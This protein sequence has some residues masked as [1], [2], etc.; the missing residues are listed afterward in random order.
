M[1]SLPPSFNAI[2]ARLSQTHPFSCLSLPQL[3]YAVKSACVESAVAGQALINEGSGGLDYLV[4]LDGELEVRRRFLNEQGMLECEVG[5]L[6]PG[7]GAGELALLRGIS[8]QA[9]VSAI[10]ASRYLRINGECMEELLAWSQCLTK[11]LN[12]VAEARERMNLV[13]QAGPF[14][15]LPLENVQRAFAALRPMVVKDG[16]VIIRQGDSGDLY[17]IIERGVAE[18]SRV[19]TA[20]GITEA[21]AVIGP[22]DGFGEEALLLGGFRNATVK[23]QTNGCLWTLRKQ[24]FDVLV[25]PTVVE[26]FSAI[27]AQELALSN[28]VRWI[29]CRYEVELEEGFLPGS[30]HLPLDALRHSTGILDKHHTYVVYCHSGRR[31]VC[32]AYLLRERG[33]LAYSL[34]GGIRDWPY[35]IVRH[36]DKI[37]SE[38]VLA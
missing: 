17:F 16:A 36:A 8:R 19:D 27:Q 23:M 7:D 20:S 14:R 38:C 24:D 31:S 25:K 10:R 9:S 30:I 12:N 6:H 32:A 21:L 28:T 37:A 34:I 3:E 13:R 22:G 4:L 26:E 5:R 2:L 1:H 15:L 33:F 11:E 35:T 29:D 18:V